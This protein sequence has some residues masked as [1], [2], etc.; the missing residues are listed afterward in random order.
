VF[1]NVWCWGFPCC[2]VL[3]CF[4][5][6]EIDFDR[7][8]LLGDNLQEAHSMSAIWLAC[9]RT[10]TVFATATPSSPT[11]S[12]GSPTVSTGS[13]ENRPGHRSTENSQLL[14]FCVQDPEPVLL[15]HMVLLT[16]GLSLYFKPP[17]LFSSTF[18][19]TTAWTT[20]ELESTAIV[21]L[22][23]NLHHNS[24]VYF[25]RFN[26]QVDSLDPGTTTKETVQELIL[27]FRNQSRYVF[28]KFRVVV[29]VARLIYELFFFEI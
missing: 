17:A 15:C 29:V 13:D 18:P 19:Q 14:Q 1:I 3:F 28:L 4:F 9:A 11:T 10:S 5:S 22:L 27:S 25:E 16:A 20:S 7:G 6:L 23:H 8:S 21:K 26:D 2:F 12:D 24:R